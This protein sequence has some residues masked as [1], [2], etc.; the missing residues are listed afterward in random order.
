[1]KI[2]LYIVSSNIYKYFATHNDIS[3]DM[4]LGM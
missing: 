4:E 1:M 3:N 2:F